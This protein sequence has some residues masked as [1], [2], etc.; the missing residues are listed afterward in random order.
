MERCRK[1]EDLQNTCRHQTTTREIRFRKRGI[2]FD[3]IILYLIVHSTDHLQ[4]QPQ[5]YLQSPSLS[6]ITIIAD[7][8]A[9][10]NMS[11]NTSDSVTGT[12]GDDAVSYRSR[13]SSTPFLFVLRCACTTMQGECFPRIEGDCLRCPPIRTS[14]SDLLQST[15]VTRL[16]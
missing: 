9:S 16:T 12:P 10:I 15:G 4:I 3:A 1:G 5:V 14:G 11:T 8:K 7:Y 13:S 2:D 6:T